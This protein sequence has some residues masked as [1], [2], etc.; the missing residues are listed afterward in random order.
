MNERIPAPRIAEQL[1]AEGLRTPRGYSFNEQRVRM[2]ML[3]KGLHSNRQRQ[4]KV[5]AKLAEN[6]WLVTGLARK[7]EISCAIIR[8]WIR[9]RRVA[10][11]KADGGRWVLTADETKCREL[12]AFQ[13][14]Q[15]RP[16]GSK[17]SAK[18]AA[19]TKAK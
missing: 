2:L 5:S 7:L 11:R 12:L 6:E 3:R 4:C 18:D 19:T 9:D 1:N 8:Q 17:N 15:R 13:A 10:A 16:N 14:S